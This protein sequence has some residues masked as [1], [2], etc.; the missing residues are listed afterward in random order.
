[1]ILNR[2]MFLVIIM[3]VMITVVF[4]MVQD[5]EVVLYAVVVA[6]IAY[7]VVNMKKDKLVMEGE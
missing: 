1:M 6:G 7:V 5:K 4:F 3:A 2:E